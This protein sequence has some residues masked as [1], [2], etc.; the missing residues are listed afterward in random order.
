MSTDPWLVI[1]ALSAAATAVATAA[2]AG[3]I[4]WTGVVARRALR[5]AKED[6]RSRTRPVMMAELRR[7]PL[8]HGTVNLLLDNLGASVASDVTVV[9]DP[10][11]PP[12]LESLPDSDLWKWIHQRYARPITTWAPHLR[13]SNVVR[14]GHDKLEPFV[15]RINYLGP[16]GTPYAD[17]YEFN[18][19]HV[20]KET[21]AGPSQAAGDFDWEKRK[22]K[23]LEALVARLD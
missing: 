7:A 20:L 23:A 1:T 5:A 19:D 17:R 18:P 10:G 21:E 12:N 2:S 4:V 16:D 11:P 9:L 3:A 13:M 15:V 22:V 14:A 6:S 8:S